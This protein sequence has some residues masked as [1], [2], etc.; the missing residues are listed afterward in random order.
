MKLTRTIGM[1]ALGTISSAM[2]EG[3]LQRTL[4]AFEDKPGYVQPLATWFG[5]FTNSGWATSARVNRGFGWEFALPVVGIAYLD[6]ADHTYTSSFDDG[7]A[8]VNAAGYDCPSTSYEVPTIM[9]PQTNVE[10]T[11]YMVDPSGQSYVS[12]SGGFADDGDETLREISTLGTAWV[13]T[14][15]SYE[16]AKLILRG[17]PLGWVSV[18]EFQGYNHLGFA[19]QYSLGHYFA[20]YLPPAYPVDVSLLTSYNFISIGYSPKDYSGELNLDITSMWHALVVGTRL[21]SHFEVFTE[22][23]YETSTLKS[24]GKLV[25]KVE[26]EDDINPRVQVDGRNGFKASF[27]IALH[28][29]SYHPAVAISQGAQ[30]A[31]NINIL[32]FGKE[33]TP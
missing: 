13:Q 15:F 10:Y 29:G 24:S 26:G 30:T 23:G 22:L 5:S 18:G 21:G 28:F 11:R 3:S 20:Q 1:V 19:L 33:G 4:K 27:N 14:S 17:A 31:N 2:A 9:G 6:Q 25:A 16:H 8:E 32:N 7:C 12:M